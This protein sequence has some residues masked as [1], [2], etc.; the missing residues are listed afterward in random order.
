MPSPHKK[1]GL[2]VK[3]KNLKLSAE[4]PSRV[5]ARIKTNAEI[6]QEPVDEE[7]VSMKKK[8]YLKKSVIKPKGNC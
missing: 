6:K 8:V 2:N 4:L 1:A 5:S 7:K 3:K